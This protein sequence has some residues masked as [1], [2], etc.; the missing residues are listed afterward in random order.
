[1]CIVMVLPQGHIC[2]SIYHPPTLWPITDT[3]ISS[4][5]DHCAFLSLAIASVI[6]HVASPCSDIHVHACKSA[7][8]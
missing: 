5:F 8:F 1:M 7:C 3:L 2:I 4:S 6:L